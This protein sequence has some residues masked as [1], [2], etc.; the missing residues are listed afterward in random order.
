MS[1]LYHKDDYTLYKEYYGYY[2]RQ[3]G[4]INGHY[5]YKSNTERTNRWPSGRNQADDLAI[6]RLRDGGWA[7]GRESAKG[8]NNCF[9]FTRNSHYCPYGRGMGSGTWKY[10]KPTT[11]EWKK[12]GMFLNRYA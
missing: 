2:K 9:F 1:N 8:S 4:K 12:S 3:P 5:W 7:V 10:Y 6:W 11:R